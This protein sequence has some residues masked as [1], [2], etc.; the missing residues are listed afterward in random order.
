MTLAGPRHSFPVDGLVDIVPPRPGNCVLGWRRLPA[1][2]TLRS[3]A[4][5]TIPCRDV[6]ITGNEPGGAGEFLRMRLREQR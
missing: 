1:Q 2:H 6:S 5:N 3:I 4:N